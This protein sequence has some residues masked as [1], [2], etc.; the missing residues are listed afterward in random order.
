MAEG[1]LKTPIPKCRLYLSFLFG[2]VWQFLL[3]KHHYEAKV[4][5]IETEKRLLCRA[6]ITNC[7][8]V[9]LNSCRIW[10]TTQLNI[11]PP[12]TPQPPQPH[13]VWIYCAFTLGRGGEVKEK[14]EGQQYTGKVPSS[15][16]ATVQKL[17]RK[18]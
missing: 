7:V 3:E 17:G 12:P 1:T 14:L 15:M 18:W 9:R 16:S 10:S 13:T 2:V 6:I 4:N 8:I 5:S 11:P